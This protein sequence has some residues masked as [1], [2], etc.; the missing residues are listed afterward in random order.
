M[1]LKA[2]EVILALIQIVPTIKSAF[3]A[4]VSFY[5]SRQI[6]GMRSEHRE[7]IRR[8]ILEHDQ[9]TLEQTIRSPVAG[10]PSGLPGSHLRDTL[11]GVNGL[12]DPQRD[13][14]KPVAE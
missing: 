8:A 1:L 13:P 4:F 10:Q 3:D 7:G 2:F 6:E 12:R 11:P 14:S 5:V 9:R